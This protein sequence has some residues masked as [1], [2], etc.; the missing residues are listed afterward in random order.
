MEKS[1]AG[2]KS[3]SPR[4]VVAAR[5][6]PPPDE[7]ASASARKGGN[8]GATLRDPRLS[9]ILLLG[10]ALL[11]LLAQSWRAQQLSHQV[12]GLEIRLEA[13]QQ[14]IDQH[15]LHVQAVQGSVGSLLEEV[16]ELDRLVQ[17]SPK[18]PEKAATRP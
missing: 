5:P 6:D 3:A 15:E 8:V 1:S 11:A 2:S 13:A 17:Q 4:L 16:R 9:L 10:V 7:P 14:L 18:R 12:G